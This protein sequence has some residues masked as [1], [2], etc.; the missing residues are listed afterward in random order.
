M[1]YGTNSLTYSRSPER[2][3]QFTWPIKYTLDHK[4]LDVH[5]DVSSIIQILKD[6]SYTFMNVFKV[7]NRQHIVNCYIFMYCSKKWPCDEVDAK[8]GKIRAYFLGLRAKENFP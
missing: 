3:L 2:T 6:I 1:G 8:K 5:V 4:F 7:K